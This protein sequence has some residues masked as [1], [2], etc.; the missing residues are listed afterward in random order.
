[1][2]GPSCSG[3]HNL[4]PLYICTGAE[5]SLEVER[6]VGVAVVDKEEATIEWTK[7]A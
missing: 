7:K 6:L 2:S 3:P 5:E 1:L 4:P